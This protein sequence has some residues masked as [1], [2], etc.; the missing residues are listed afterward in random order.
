MFD[1]QTGEIIFDTDQMLLECDAAVLE[2]HNIHKAFVRS[3]VACEARSGVCSKCYGANIAL[4]KPAEVGDTVGIIAAQ[5]IGSST[6]RLPE[7]KK[8]GVWNRQRV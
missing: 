2:G 8:N 4:N 5:S 3:V 1:P 6:Y 7:C